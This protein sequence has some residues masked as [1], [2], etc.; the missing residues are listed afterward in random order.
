MARALKKEINLAMA[1]MVLE[2]SGNTPVQ[3]A[4]Q[5]FPMCPLPR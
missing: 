5:A 1:L 3:A 4:A 2:T